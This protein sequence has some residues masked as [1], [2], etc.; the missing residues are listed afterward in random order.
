MQQQD[1]LWAVER[2]EERGIMCCRCL[3]LNVL[4]ASGCAEA[5]LRRAFLQRRETWIAGLV[6]ELD[7]SHACEPVCHC[8]SV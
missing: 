8:C 5:E 6:A 1:C 7:D 4:A 2:A 3:L